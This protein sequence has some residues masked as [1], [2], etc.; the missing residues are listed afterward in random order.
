MV[1]DDASLL[2]FVRK[3]LNE[4][5]F[6]VDTAASGQEAIAMVAAAPTRYS[7]AVIDYQM[8]GQDGGETTSR[9]LAINPK[10][11]VLIYSGDESGNAFYVGHRNGAAGLLDKREGTEAFLQEVRKMCRLAEDELN[12]DEV[13]NRADREK[14]IQSVGLVGSSKALATIAAEV[15]RLKDQSN[16]VLISGETGTG[17]ELIARALHGKRGPFIPVNCSYFKMSPGTARSELFGYVKG[18]FTGADGD[19]RGLFEEAE[20]GT[21]FLDEVHEL[22]EDAQSGLLRSLQERVITRVGS[23]KEIPFNCRV[24]AASNANIRANVTAGKFKE[25]LY[26]RLGQSVIVVPPLRDRIDDLVPLIRHFCAKWSKENRGRKRSFKLSTVQKLTKYSWGGNVRQLQNVVNSTLYATDREDIRIEDLAAGFHDP[27]I[28]S[29]PSTGSLK[30]RLS[31][32]EKK[33]VMEAAAESRTVRDAA[34]KMG[35]SHANLLRLFQKHGLE[36]KTAIGSEFK[37]KVQGTNQ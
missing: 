24:I 32:I 22:P 2:H 31:E 21:L 29:V 28:S 8:P 25:D 5:G 11:R 3:F 6:G 10:I 30:E 26:H 36:S 35:I 1:D 4:N 15:Q 27:L 20:G 33:I 34:R 9:I 37:K 12:L 14:L 18:A 7:V 23:A 17:K 19:K 16:S 13:S